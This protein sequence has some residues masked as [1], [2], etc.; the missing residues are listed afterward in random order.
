LDFD[1]CYHRVSALSH[2][3]LI[4][5]IERFSNAK[6]LCVGDVMLDH[7][8]YGDVNRISPEAPIPVV[9]VNQERSM[10]GGAG[11]V[12]RNLSSLGAQAVLLTVVGADSAANLIQSELSGLANCSLHAV[13]DQTRKTS[14]KTRYISGSQ[15]LLR[16]DNE[17]THAIEDDI[18]AELL[19]RFEKL[20]SD[21]DVVILSDYAKGVLQNDRAARFI[22]AARAADKPVFVDPK[23]RS[24]ARYKGASL[25]KPNLQELAEATNHP[26]ATDDALEA[27]ALSVIK[28][29]SIGAVLVTR[30]ALGMMLVRA[31][32]EPVSLRSLAREIFD[33]SGAGDTV[34]AAFAA[35][36][37][38]GM[39]MEDAMR[40]AN[41]AA[42]IVVAKVGTATTTQ[43]ELLAE[44]EAGDALAP[45]TRVVVL[46]EAIQRVRLWRRLGLKVGLVNRS[47]GVFDAAAIA[48]LQ[49]ARQQCDRLI[50]ATESQP[51]LLASMVYVDLVITGTHASD[52]LATLLSG[53]VDLQPAH[54]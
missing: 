53:V 30:G 8:I 15:Q 38:T 4:P 5:F 46:E 41:V 40:V 52:T 16:V 29:H 9:R 7:F 10:L 36:V 2:Q 51:L 24:F 45:D 47:F 50:V 27:A 28:Q 1:G 37:A 26:V 12:V 44:L 25:V 20:A 13:T 35:G 14:V 6:V 23:G 39:P 3:E 21:C 17:S 33:V 43:E 32:A 49:Q 34:A 19:R 42:G 48:F 54:L 31:D 22:T 11:N 18:F